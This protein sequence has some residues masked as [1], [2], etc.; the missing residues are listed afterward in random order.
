MSPTLE[1]NLMVRIAW[2]RSRAEETMPCG[3]PNLFRRCFVALAVAV[4]MGVPSSGSADPIT[5]TFTVF[6]ALGDPVNARPSTGTFTFNSDL[7]PPEG[8]NVQDFT[9][10]GLASS[11]SFHWSSTLWSTSNASVVELQFNPEGDLTWWAMGGR[12]PDGCCVLGVIIG[13][14]TSVIDDF[15]LTA[16]AFFY[17][18]A[19]IEGSLQGRVLTD[20]PPAVVPEPGTIILVASGLAFLA[21][22][23]RRRM[24]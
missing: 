7:I 20:V 22:R 19:G 16:R 15:W 13:P 9:V 6:P 21:N 18:N 1:G 8:G 11:I 2:L 23:A 10:P 4:S 3:N 24:V 14:A 5:V 17:T 12:A